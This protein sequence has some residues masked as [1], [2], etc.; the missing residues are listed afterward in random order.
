[1]CHSLV[2][3]I[4]VNDQPIPNE[5]ISLYAE[6]YAEPVLYDIDR[7]KGLGLK[8]VNDSFVT[9]QDNIIRHDAMKVSEILLSIK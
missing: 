6:E 3:Y 5:I 2:D 1:V 8:V 9:Y 7:L 4:L